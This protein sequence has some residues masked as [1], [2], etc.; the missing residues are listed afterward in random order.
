M[1]NPSPARHIFHKT[2]HETSHFYRNIE[3]STFRY[4]NAYILTFTKSCRSIEPLLESIFIVQPHRQEI[5]TVL[6]EKFSEISL[7]LKNM[8]FLCGGSNSSSKPS[9]SSIPSS[10]PNILI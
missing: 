1:F 2:Y 4:I 7:N 10:L 8:L 5:H 9:N 3:N 6:L